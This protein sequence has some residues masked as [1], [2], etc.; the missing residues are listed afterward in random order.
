M[1]LPLSRTLSPGGGEGKSDLFLPLLP[2][3]LFAAC[4]AAAPKENP[5][6]QPPAA[7]WLAVRAGDDATTLEVPARVLPGPGAN[8]VV[9]PPLRATILRIRTRAGD[10]VTAGAPLIDVVMPELLDAAGRL[11]GARVRLQ[12]WSER[13]TQLT[14]LRAEGL[15][16][17]LDVSEAAA[18]VAESKADLQAARAILL[19]AGVRDSDAAA[20]LAGN[21][22]LSLKAPVAGVVTQLSASVGES[23]EPSAGPLVSL[24][25]AGPTRVE[26]RFT[27]SVA[28]GHYDFIGA[29]G[30]VSLTLLSR[31]PVADA[32]D[33]TFLAWFEPAQELPAGSLG[34]VVLRGSASGDVF[35]VPARAIQRVD[36]ASRVETKKGVVVVEVARCEAVDCFVR[37]GLSVNDEVSAR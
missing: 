36:G 26:A 16:K 2:L 20:L 13:L 35:R 30:T 34:R 21:G 19:S 5:I 7:T 1:T 17:S 28:D 10:T 31:A 14:Q 12:A 32:R 6:A 37:G 25:S 8:T 15:A 9:T 27:Q 11:E 18:R 24:S 33:G 3:L 22:S 29:Q 4:T 23:R